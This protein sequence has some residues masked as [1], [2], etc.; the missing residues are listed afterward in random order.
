[1]SLAADHWTVSL[2]QGC[3]DSLPAALLEA[4][5]RAWCAARPAHAVCAEYEHHPT[6]KCDKM[7]TNSE[8]TDIDGNVSKSHISKSKRQ[9]ITTTTSTTLTLRH[10]IVQHALTSKPP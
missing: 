4:V 5:Y 1:M 6:P 3:S 10:Q 2:Q 8:D 9:S 7:H